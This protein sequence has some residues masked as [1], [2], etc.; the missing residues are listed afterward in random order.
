MR[1]S[2]APA[3]TASTPWRLNAPGRST[4]PRP[5]ARHSLR[6]PNG[7]STSGRRSFARLGPVPS[8][9][10]APSSSRY[11]RT[12]TQ[13]SQKLSRPPGS[14]PRSER[15]R[16][17]HKGSLTPRHPAPVQAHGQGASGGSE[18]WPRFGRDR[19]TRPGRSGTTEPSSAASRS[20]E[21]LIGEN[22]VVESNGSRP[23]SRRAHVRGA[24]PPSPS[25][26][27]RRL[28]TV[29]PLTCGRTPASSSLDPS[30]G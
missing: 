4:K 16:R 19:G 2:G 3:G 18:A 1:R 10:I 30:A 13:P 24:S 23:C 6:R 11:F 20:V 28:G 25:R 5:P 26:F 21:W 27:D 29:S 15:E 17:H 14:A 12:S 8:C 7:V 9:V 22:H